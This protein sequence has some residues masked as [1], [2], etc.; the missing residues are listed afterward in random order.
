MAPL[1][2]VLL[3]LL[4][5]FMFSSTFVLQPGVQ[6]RLHDRILG[7]G[8]PAS[9]KVVTLT[10]AGEIYIEQQRV[11]VARLRERLAEF[12]A[13]GAEQSVILKADAA[14]PH[15]LVLSVMNEI[16]GARLNVVIAAQSFDASAESAP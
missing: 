4:L 3:L 13:A 1:V 10:Q 9:R 15:G 14:V 12:A 2:S 8:T 11:D 7:A 5:F 6:V 16:L